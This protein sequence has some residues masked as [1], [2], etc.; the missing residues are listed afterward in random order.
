MADISTQY[1]TKTVPHYVNIRE[2]SIAMILIKKLVILTLE[3]PLFRI[4]RA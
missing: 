4:F 1:E 2:E 3:L